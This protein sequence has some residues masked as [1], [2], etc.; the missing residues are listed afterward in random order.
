MKTLVLLDDPSPTGEAGDRLSFHIS[1]SLALARAAVPYRESRGLYAPEELWAGY[2]ERVKETLDLARRADEA[3]WKTDPRFKAENLKLFSYLHFLIKINY[4]QAYYYAWTL[5]RALAGGAYDRLVY[6]DRPGPAVDQYHLFSEG[7]PLLGR[8]AEAAALARGLIADGRRGPARPDAAPLSF[9]QPSLKARARSLYRRLQNLAGRATRRGELEIL[10][11]YC[12]ELEALVG[13]LGSEGLRAVR[14]I[15]PAKPDRV[16]EKK[17]AFLERLA[18]TLAD[19]R[20]KDIPLGK[21]LAPMFESMAGELENYFQWYK[22]VE[23][24]GDWRRADAVCVQSLAPL[25]PPA[26]FLHKLCEENGIPVLCWMHGGYGAYHSLPG[27]DVT[28]Y[29]FTGHHVVYG[30]AVA[31]SVRSPQSVLRRLPWQPCRALPLGSPYFEERYKNSR[32]PSCAKKIVMLSIG[33]LYK[34]NQFYFGYNKPEAEFCGYE[35]HAAVIRLLAKFQEE[36]SIVIKDYP[37]LNMRPEWENLL[38]ELNARR[39]RVVTTEQTY[40]TA[41]NKSDL[42]IFTW[43]STT[44]MEALQT[45]ADVFLLDKSDVTPDAARALRAGIVFERDTP[46][47]LGKLERYLAAGRFYTQDKKPV[48]DYFLAPADGRAGRLKDFIRRAAHAS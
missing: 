47:F 2:P 41:L 19:L 17:Q 45:E 9:G 38:S 32:R 27:F 36:Y 25:F 40:T 33:G 4:D 24:A 14:Y 20:L 5:D 23:A 39:V 7:Y 13:P 6:F 16:Y 10:S 37:G 21:A 29:R 8:V 35:E 31:D 28:D 30:H 42:N 15:E 18:P 22:A 43:V 1:A 11:V 48:K 46:A 34:R 12:K 26:V 44:F 3:L